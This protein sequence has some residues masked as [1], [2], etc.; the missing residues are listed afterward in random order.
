MNC[1]ST[2]VLSDESAE[3]DLWVLALPRLLELALLFLGRWFPSLLP[4]PFLDPW[5]NFSGTYLLFA[6]T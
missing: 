5:P 2:N 1:W 4:V 3:A 6:E